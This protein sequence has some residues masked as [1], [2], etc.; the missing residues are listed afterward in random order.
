MTPSANCSGLASCQARQ[1]S[2]DRNV[3]I[4]LGYSEVVRMVRNLAHP[5]RYVQDH[6]P[7]RV[8]AKYLRRQF[9]VVLLCRDWL[10]ERNNKALREHMREESALSPA[11][12]PA[13][14][15]RRGTKAPCRPACLGWST[16]ILRTDRASARTECPAWRAAF[17]VSRPIPLLAPMIRTVAT[18]SILPDGPAR[19]PSCAMQ[20]IRGLAENTMGLSRR[21]DARI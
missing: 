17:T 13:A 6:Y 19:S 5:A 16:G 11:A 7:S 3:T 14:R 12:Q 21:R 15:A 20:A 4:A 1:N 9:E 18:A 8:T 10:V 2:C